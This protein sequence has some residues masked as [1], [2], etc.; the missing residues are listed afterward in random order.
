MK[1]GELG[2]EPSTCF[3]ACG[4]NLAH[5]YL[6]RYERGGGKRIYRHLSSQCAR[7]APLT[8][9][10]RSQPLLNMGQSDNV[11]STRVFE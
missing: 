7:P 1:L 11:A 2:K 8:A 6:R 4:P 9:W 10:G 5:F 3:P